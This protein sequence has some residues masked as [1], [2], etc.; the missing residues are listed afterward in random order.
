[1]C[2]DAT[3]CMV[4]FNKSNSAC[5][6]ADLRNQHAAPRRAMTAPT[7]TAVCPMPSP[8]CD[9]VSDNE[10]RC[11]L[12]PQLG[13][14]CLGH[15]PSSRRRAHDSA[16]PP[17]HVRAGH[18]V[19]EL[20]ELHPELTQQG[21]VTHVWRDVSGVAGDDQPAPASPVPAPHRHIGRGNRRARPCP[22]VGPRLGRLPLQGRF[23]SQVLPS[24]TPA[25]SAHNPVAPLLRTPAAVEPR[26]PVP[27]RRAV[28]Q[29]VR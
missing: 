25:R 17:R 23:T 21:M 5:H 8:T 15:R 20:R 28:R 9:Y 26:P 14:R 11:T 7:S 22:P 12:K 6:H 19:T 4:T 13:G 18:R 3:G 1:M 24:A 10:T 27:G 2:F 29:G 16:E